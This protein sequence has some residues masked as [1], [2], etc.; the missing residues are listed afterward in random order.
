MKGRLVLVIFLLLPVSCKKDS[1][2]Q[3]ILTK[4]QMA[5]WMIKVYMAEAR[6]GSWAIS[7]D[8][9]YKL[10][11][12]YQDTLKQRNGLT[13]STLMKSYLYY[14][15]NSKDME[16]IYDIVIDSLNLREQRVLQPAPDTP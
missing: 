7:R 1:T 6:T 5:D 8:S 15:E 12:P 3:G 16:D 10:F 11:V 2:P 4:S 9:A 13:D 14:L